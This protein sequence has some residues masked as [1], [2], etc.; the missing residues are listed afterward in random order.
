V[1]WSKSGKYPIVKLAANKKGGE[2]TS[3]ELFGT[4]MEEVT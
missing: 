4:Q 2:R 1:E 3:L